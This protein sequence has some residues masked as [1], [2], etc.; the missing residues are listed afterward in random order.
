MSAHMTLFEELA[1][2]GYIIVCIGHPYWN[3]FVYGSGGEVIPFDG[4]NEKY[5][6]WWAEAN[7]ARVEEAK[8]QVT[9]AKTTGCPG[10]RF[11]QAQ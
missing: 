2:H 3:P 4:Q 5:Q 6:A 11:H 8:S 1:S 7:S 10:A 9:L